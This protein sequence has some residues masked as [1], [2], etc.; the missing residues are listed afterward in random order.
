MDGWMDIASNISSR[1][2]GGQVKFDNIKTILL[3][4][5]KFVIYPTE[6]SGA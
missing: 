4:Y 3:F 6:R 2:F 5:V 1:K